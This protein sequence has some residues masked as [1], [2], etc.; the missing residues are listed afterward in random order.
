MKKFWLVVNI[1]F[2]IVMVTDIVLLIFK[3]YIPAKLD[4]GFVF[5]Y[6]AFVTFKQITDSILNDEQTVETNGT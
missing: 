4:I 1:L 3:D 6:A 2:V 5:F